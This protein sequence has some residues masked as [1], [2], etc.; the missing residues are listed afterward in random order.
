MNVLLLLVVVLVGG[1]IMM[2]VISGGSTRANKRGARPSRGGRAANSTARANLSRDQISQRWA[3]IMAV[4]RTG[5]SGLKSALNDADK[6][7]DQAM[8]QAGL[9]GETMGERL[10]SARG[11]FDRDT[12]DGIWRAHKLRNTMAHEIEFDI[13]PSQIREALTDFERGLKTLGVL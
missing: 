9:R 6:L 5:G 8:K 3:Q 4:S 7:F 10:K 13:V 1:L 2:M 12:Y 11:R